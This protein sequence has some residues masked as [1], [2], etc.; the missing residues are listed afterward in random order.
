MIEVVYR[1]KEAD[2]IDLREFKDIGELI[3]WA[4]RQVLLE[5]IEIIS[6]RDI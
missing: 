6:Y 1:R 5:P 3:D 4:M 2:I